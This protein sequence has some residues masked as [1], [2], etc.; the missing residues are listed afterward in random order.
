MVSKNKEQEGLDGFIDSNQACDKETRHS[1]IEYIF[2]LGNNNNMVLQET[3]YVIL[4][5]LPLKQILVHFLKDKR[6]CFGN[7]VLWNQESQIENPFLFYTIIKTTLIQL[8]TWSFMLKLNILKHIIIIFMKMYKLKEYIQFLPIQKQVVNIL[9]KLYGRIKYSKF[10]K[11]F[12]IQGLNIIMQRKKKIKKI[13]TLEFFK[14]S[15]LMVSVQITTHGNM[16]E[17]WKGMLITTRNVSHVCQ[18]LSLDFE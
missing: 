11:K 18:M 8:E 7:E 5:F 1:K 17:L 4:F 15:L 10:R 3:T 6:Q 12:G 2:K 9:I 13:F 16:L 14:F